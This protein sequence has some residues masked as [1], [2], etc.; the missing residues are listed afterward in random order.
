MPAEP[1]LRARHVLGHRAAR[2][3]HA[4]V[5]PPMADAAL[6][7]VAAGVF[8]RFPDL[9]LVFAHADAG[10]AFFWLEFFDNTYLRQRHLE[11]IRARG[12][13]PVPE[14]VHP[15][16][17]LVHLPAGPLGGEE[18]APIRFPSTCLWGSHFPSDAA[19]WPD[20]RSAGR[21][22]HR[23]ASRRRTPRRSWPGTLLVCIAS[24]APSRALP[25]TSSKGTP[26]RAPASVAGP[27]P[28]TSPL[29]FCPKDGSSRGVAMSEP[30]V[31]F[32]IYD[33]DN[34]MY[35]TPEA[36][37]KHLP[38]AYAGLIK[39]VQVKGRTKIAIKNVITD[40]IPNPTFEV[41]ARP[42][43]QEDYFRDGNPEGKSR[44]EI[45]GEPMRSLGRVLRARNRAS[46]SWTSW[47]STGAVM[48]PTLASL[49]EERLSDDPRAM[50]VVVHAL[51]QWMYEHW[52]FNYE[53]RIYPT[54]VITLPIVDEA[55]EE[56]EWVVEPRRQDRA[57]PP[58]A[59]ARLR[60]DAVVRAARVRPVL[61]EGRGGRHRGRDALVRR[62]HDQVHE[63]LGR[64]RQRRVPA[65]PR[66][67]RVRGD[68]PLPAP[69]H[70]RRH[71]LG[72]VPRAVHPVPDAP[73]LARRERLARGCARCSSCSVAP[74]PRTRTCSTRTRSRCSSATCGCTRSTKTTRVEL[75]ARS[76]APIACCSAPTTRT[77][78]VS[79]TRR[80]TSKELHGFTHDEVARIMGGNLADAL[81]IAA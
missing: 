61:A 23:R 28:P 17:L 36:F 3:D 72:G 66:A 5:K 35:E 22:D 57:D 34:H 44:R 40:Y 1:A 49:L 20:D 80:A 69:R 43:A 11:R 39:Y 76:S 75:V 32:P 64:H 73:G 2:R 7:L 26:A 58:G 13:R 54:P 74:T 48:W 70:L 42:G 78:R 19:D 52:T 60:R 62:R 79:R 25:T 47:A 56:L 46:S 9:R 50:H 67:E 31:D 6:P 24:R 8:D 10:W 71:A 30:V 37:T 45:M 15:A 59:G 4:G 51:N 41:V 14:R 53:D 27:V 18:P 55:I 68:V 29:S 81:K 21:A 38:P 33:A 77:P 16:A 63:R 65:V 12:S